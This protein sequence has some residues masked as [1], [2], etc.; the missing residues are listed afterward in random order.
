MEPKWATPDREVLGKAVGSQDGWA[1]AAQ[2][3]GAGGG[4]FVNSTSFL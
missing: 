1:F 4:V 2:Q 3:A